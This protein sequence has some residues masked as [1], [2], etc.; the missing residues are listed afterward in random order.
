MHPL[1]LERRFQ[2]TIFF[3]QI[4]DDMILVSVDPTGK[5]GD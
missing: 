4:A 5:H 3:A 2:D 1:A